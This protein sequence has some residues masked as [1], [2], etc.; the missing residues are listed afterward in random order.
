VPFPEDT[1]PD[2]LLHWPKGGLYPLIP[3]ANRISDAQLRMDGHAHP[4]PPH[5][6]AAP[7]TLHGPAHRLPW[8]VVRSGAAEAMLELRHPG[9]GEWPWKFRAVLELH[10]TPDN[11]RIDIMLLN[12]DERVMPAGI[13]L[14]PYFLHSATDLLGFRATTDWPVKPDYLA[15]PPVAASADHA[16]PAA[17]PSGAV[18]LYRSGWDGHCTLRHA[19]GHGLR[20]EASKTLDHLVIHRPA[21]VAYLCLEPCSH[22]VDGFNHAANGVAGTGRVLLAPGEKLRGHLILSS[23]GGGAA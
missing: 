9:T 5:P 17:L 16:P 6:D 7:H 11:L 3:Y 13:G 8:Q 22:A 12:Q 1:S 14:H 20:M 21:N 23:L 2:A 18:N 15:A 10:L 19:D 4:L